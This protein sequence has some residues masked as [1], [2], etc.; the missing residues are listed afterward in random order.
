MRLVIDLRFNPPPARHAADEQLVTLDQLAGMGRRP[1]QLA[2]LL[3]GSRWDEL[4]VLRDERPLSGVQAGG[5]GLAALA[6]A[7]R[8]TLERPGGARS[9]GRGA[10]LARASADFAVAMPRELVRSALLARR[11]ARL[12]ATPFELPAPVRRPERVTYL[13]TEPSLRWMGLHVGGAATHTS[14]V[15]NGFAAAGLDVHVFAPERPAGT[16]AVPCTPVEARRLY[17]LVH[18]L[19]LFD[20]ADD[21]VA[22]AAGRPAD[23]VYQRYALGSHAGL[24]LARRLGVPLILEFNGSEIWTERHWGGG[25]V[26]LVTTLSALERRNLTD[27]TLVVVVSDVLRDQLLEAGIAPERVLVNP[28]GVDVDALAPMRARAPQAWRAELGLP[29]APTVGFIGT[30]GLWHGVKVLPALIEA[31]QRE[32]PDTRWQLVGD[33]PLRAE[34]E[35]ELRERG[36]TDAVELPGALPHAEAVRRLAACDAFV[37]PHV[38]NPDGTRFFG[39]P[40]KLFEYMGLRRPIV[41]SDLDQIGEVL[42]DGRTGLLVEP[43]NAEAAAEGVVRLLADADL[44]ER[45]A[46]AALEE[47]QRTYAWTA[48]CERILDAV[49]ALADARPPVA[50]AAP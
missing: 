43:A 27:A 34:V 37:S 50:H 32:R 20:Y 42:E 30:F 10:F 31:V 8:F 25:R 19:T 1:A 14:G 15:V 29:Q 12:A 36:L 5:E 39:S 46:A 26:P 24:T 35:A 38:P 3:L 11:A 48:H 9:A 28:N 22:A 6:R 18:W 44:R 47:A 41:A 33:G 23:A 7:R 45:L 40:T 21:V 16:E 17:Q 4:R 2:R 49:E 13:R